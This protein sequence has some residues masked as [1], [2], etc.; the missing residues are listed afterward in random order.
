MTVDGKK[1]SPAGNHG[2]R[3]DRDKDKQGDGET[4]F[5]N[6][7]AWSG[8]QNQHSERNGDL[9][10]RAASCCGTIEPCRN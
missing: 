7:K 10:G 6:R 4:K 9:M 5:F 3:K 2:M 1:K 8:A